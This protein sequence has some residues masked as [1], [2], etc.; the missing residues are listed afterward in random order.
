MLY[1]SYSGVRSFSLRTV[2]TEH[3]TQLFL[4]TYI[5]GRGSW[6]RVDQR[7]GHSVIRVGQM[8]SSQDYGICTV[9]LLVLRLLMIVI[10][11]QLCLSRN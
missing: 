5:A 6:I 3:V 1:R 8:Q 11:A 10:S 7:G 9:I 4:R 2:H